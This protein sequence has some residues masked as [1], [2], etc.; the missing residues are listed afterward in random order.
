M[1]LFLKRTIFALYLVMIIL[2]AVFPFSAANVGALN[3][4]YVL[5]FRMDHILHVLAFVPLYPLAAWLFRPDSLKSSII[6]LAA[7]L[8]IA[9][10][11]EYIQLFIDYRAY[12]PADLISN[13]VG[14]FAGRFIW[15]FVKK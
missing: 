13:M 15:I 4:M 7:G 9:A 14:V 1:S 5:D 2:L 6:L 8:L 12:N 3:K 11:A 10:I